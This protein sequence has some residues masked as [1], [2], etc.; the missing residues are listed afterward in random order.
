MG[1]L[2]PNNFHPTSI[3]HDSYS[4]DLG[5]IGEESGY[6]QVI[7]GKNVAD[8][9]WHDVVIIQN[10]KKVT[11]MLDKET[12]SMVAPG[13]FHRLDLDIML[14]VGG[15]DRIEQR[16]LRVWTP[17]TKNYK[18]CLANVMFRSRDILHSAKFNLLNTK[19][20]GHV[21]FQC[22]S[23]SYAPM[24]FAD[25]N[26]K[27]LLEREAG[28]EETTLSAR[29]RTFE[30]N[31]IIATMATTN[32]HVTLAV[33]NG[34][35]S[36]NITF[37]HLIGPEKKVSIST[38]SI[39][40]GDWHS[41]KIR[42]EKK[43]NSMILQVDQAIKTFVFQRHFKLTRELGKFTKSLRLGGPSISLPGFVG[44]L[45]NIHLDGKNVTRES[46]KPAQ[47]IGITNS[48]IPKDL[49][50]P[51]PCLNGGNCSQ[52]HGQFSCKCPKNLFKGEHCER[53]IYKRTCDEIK[54][55][56]R[57]RNGTYRIS[58][59]GVD[60]FNVYCNMN[61]KLGAATIIRHTLPP[62]MRVAGKDI[63]F[64]C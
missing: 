57:T 27:I 56:G 20:R 45:Q 9:K 3:F 10:G 21:P 64:H 18:G 1:K 58:P 39:D 16:K 52:D 44:C 47:M 7:V 11:V 35:V 54:K 55:S 28:T 8:N 46:L 32:G 62:N 13:P 49:C 17:E 50:F 38:G 42:I 37:N 12:K 34:K 43:Q 15:I 51:N 6:H 19:T 30:A 14:Y 26:S 31:G 59:N 29:I 33:I 4:A 63:F 25:S 48:C 22:I 40:D 41:V 2:F 60:S 5:S 24:S 53:S 36:F 23:Q 61:H